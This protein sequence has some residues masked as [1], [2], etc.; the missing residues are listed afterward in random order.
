MQLEKIALTG[1]GCTGRRSR[2]KSTFSVLGGVMDMEKAW[3]RV[4]RKLKK[5]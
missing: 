5:Y 1:A 2:E 4:L 3:G